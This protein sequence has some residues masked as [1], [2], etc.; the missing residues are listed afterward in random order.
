MEI[1]AYIAESYSIVKV[2]LPIE[3]RSFICIGWRAECSYCNRE[4]DC[5]GETLE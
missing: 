2:F 4:G 5:V 3:K 1:I